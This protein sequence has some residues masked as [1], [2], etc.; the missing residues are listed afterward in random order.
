[1]DEGLAGPLSWG[2]PGLRGA[3]SLSGD[4]PAREE[5]G[6][7]A[8]MRP[9]RKLIR[10]RFAFTL[11]LLAAGPLMLAGCGDGKIA[12][13]P[14][15]GKVVVDGKPA[16]AAIV[17]FCPEKTGDAEFERQRPFSQTDAEGNYQLRTFEAG[18][19]APAG[20]YKIMVRWTAPL[21]GQSPAGDGMT[22]RLRNRYTNPDQSGLTYTVVEGQNEVP[23]FELTTK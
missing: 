15:K 8:R 17:I 2:K 23:P 12:R 3:Q 20:N 1:M 21:P 14:V 9:K 6:V 10:A 4:T 13:Y 16:Q 7:H 19:G 5:L 11:A 18:D 22:D